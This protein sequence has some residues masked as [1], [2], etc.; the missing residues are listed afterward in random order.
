MKESDTALL[1]RTHSSSPGDRE[2]LEDYFRLSVS[3][4][5]LY[6][7]W[8]LADPNFREKVVGVEGLRL[9]RQDP[10]E[11][12]I[13]FICSSNNNV[14]RISAMLN[15]MC[16]SFGSPLG[17]AGGVIHYAFPTLAVL[18]GNKVEAT[19]RGLGF[20]YRAAYVQQTAQM[21]MEQLGGEAWLQSLRH[22]SYETARSDLQRLPGVGP[23]VADCVCLMGLDKLQAV[24][25]D[26]HV[27]RIAERDYGLKKEGRGV[28]AGYYKRVGDMFHSVFGS[29]AGWAQAVSGIHIPCCRV[30]LIYPPTML[31]SW[32]DMMT[33]Q[34]CHGAVT[35]MMS[36]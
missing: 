33:G 27:L 21:I 14:T 24:P 31:S 8:G 30:G 23:K 35:M 22:A 7:E 32:E 10:G 16:E 11:A 1:Y 6:R 12:L 3:C 5:D 19:L 9:L 28:S 20:G 25:V 34:G 2:A 13:A 15:R 29:T 17:E 18:A 4:S 36:L 26:T